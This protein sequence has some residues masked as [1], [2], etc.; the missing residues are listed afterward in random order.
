MTSKRADPSQ[1]G[2]TLIE[3]VVAM[4]V[5]A[6]IT[7][8]G[9]Q[10]LTG[11]LHL[12]GR[13]SSM[14]DQAENLGQAT[15]LLRHDL[16]SVVPMLFF[17]PDRLPPQSALRATD[18]GRGLSMSIATQPISGAPLGRVDWRLD[19]GTRTLTRRS[20]PT[21]FPAAASQVSPEVTVWSDV[22]TLRLRS[23]WQ[24]IGWVSGLSPPSAA[25]ITAEANV[26]EDGGIVLLETYSDQLPLAIEITI[27]TADQGEIQLVE[28]F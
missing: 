10:A 2:L 12:R 8:M 3:L 22:S 9:L 18:Q 19:P 21:L 5:F 27:V 14:A 4:A 23:Y 17:P 13:L 26:D 16:Q 15:A 25:T 1:L 11:T 6:L 20:W 28:S 24:T 7:V